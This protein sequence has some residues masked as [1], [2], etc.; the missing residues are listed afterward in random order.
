[1]S[2]HAALKLAQDNGVRVDVD[3]SDLILDAAQEPPSRVVDALRCHKSEIIE[4]LRE[5]EDGW[6]AIDWNAYFDERAAIAEF[7]SDKSRIDAEAQAFECCIVEWLNRNPELSDAGG[8]AWCKGLDEDGHVVVPF[9]NEAQ[10]HIWLHFGC[11]LSWSNSRH[12][13][14]AEALEGFGIK[15]PGKR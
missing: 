11:W 3:G 2:A 7:N 8:C 6:S 4:L 9:E 10:G 14:A 12:V 15:F 1:M 13:C 5:R